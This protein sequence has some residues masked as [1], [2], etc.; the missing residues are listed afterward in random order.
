MMKDLKLKSIN[1]FSKHESAVWNNWSLVW[2]CLP[3]VN[4]WST[5]QRKEFLKLVQL[6]ASGPEQSFILA[7]QKN[8]GLLNAFNEMVNR[9]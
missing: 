7:L 8:K 6:K 2:V 5:L 3:G 4:K 1:H 9:V